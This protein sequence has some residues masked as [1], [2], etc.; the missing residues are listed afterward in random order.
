MIASGYEWLFRNATLWLHNTLWMVFN[1]IRT[2]CHKRN[3]RHNAVAI[4]M[5]WAQFIHSPQMYTYIY[6]LHSCGM[7]SLYNVFPILINHSSYNSAFNTTTWKRKHSHNTV[8]MVCVFSGEGGIFA[9]CNNIIFTLESVKVR[10]IITNLLS[11]L[12]ERGF[13][14]IWKSMYFFGSSVYCPYIVHHTL[15]HFIS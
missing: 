2:T 8:N 6:T 14:H 3:V 4:R 15:P 5:I 1:L 9:Y 10:F 11:S 12:K 7:V 13:Y